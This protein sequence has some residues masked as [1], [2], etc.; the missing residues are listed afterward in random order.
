M[1]WQQPDVPELNFVP[2]LALKT[3]HPCGVFGIMTVEDGLTVENDHVVITVG[4][5][6][7]V[8]PL[9]VQDSCGRLP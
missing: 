8:V 4:S 1:K 2:F 7:V 3:D 5:D 6:V 9:P